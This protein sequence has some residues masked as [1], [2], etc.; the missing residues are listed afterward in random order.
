MVTLYQYY[1]DINLCIAIQN[2]TY[3]KS[4]HERKE[5]HNQNHKVWCRLHFKPLMTSDKSLGR[6]VLNPAYTKMIVTLSR[7]KL[8]LLDTRDSQWQK[9]T[10]L[11]SSK[12]RQVSGV[13][14]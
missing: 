4:N 14:V 7:R 11:A 2:C 12:T 13:D 5:F 10:Y 9:L 1:F 6:L 8:D 3:D